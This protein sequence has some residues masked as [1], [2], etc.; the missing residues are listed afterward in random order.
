MKKFLILFIGILSLTLLD[1][2]VKAVNMNQTSA[3]YD[4]YTTGPNGRRIKTQ[5]AYEPAGVVNQGLNLLNP[6]DLY[7]KDDLIYI[8]DTGNKR[9]VK[10][11]LDGKFEV[12]ISN[13]NQPTGIHVD[14]L[15]QI[16]VA[17]KGNKEVY[18]YD[19]N[20]LLLDTFGRPKEPI[21]G[22]NSPYVPTKIVT[23]PRGIMYI[24]GEGSTG[25]LIQL[26]YAGDFLGFYGTNETS[27]TWYQQLAEWFNLD[28]AK[29]IPTS[30]LNLA[31]DLKGSVFTTSVQ[32]SNQIKKFNIASSIVL[33]LSDETQPVSI[34]INDFNNIYTISD[35]G[36]ITEYDSYGN[37][38]FKFGGLDQGN[39][40][41]GLFVNPVD[42][43]LD[44]N[45][46]IYVLDKATSQIQML[47]RA[48]FTVMVHQGLEDFNNGIYSIEQWEEV[49][50]MN[51]MFALANS[52]IARAR[53]R[54]LEYQEALDY[55]EIAADRVGY[56]DSFWQ[57]RYQWMQNYLGNVLILLISFF[58]L[59][60]VLKW[61]DKK[62]HIYDPLRKWQKQLLEIKVIR[63]LSLIFRM[64]R[65]PVDTF[66]EIKRNH[67]SSYLA[68]TI[69]FVI[70]IGLNVITAYQTAFIFNY[71]NL[72]SYSLIREVAVLGSIIILFVFSNY[73]VSTL[74]SGEGFFK[75]IYQT[76]AY[77][78][79]PYIILTIP[80]VLMSHVLTFNEVFIF[81]AM[82]QIK[83]YWSLGL[84]ILM[85]KEVHNYNIKA[86]IKNIFLTLFVMVMIVVIVFL[87]Y[88][89]ANQLYEYVFG[90][91]REVIVRAS[92]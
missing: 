9:I 62:Y 83:F 46:N 47:Q 35:Q 72:E 88:L 84:I 60:K 22:Q 69:L 87:I 11:D 13:L 57:I 45:N 68:S 28:L 37:M 51:S 4:T 71:T 39:R 53:F 74:S 34:A 41:L 76:T 7:I 58:I 31:I 91:I 81:Q 70:F 52:A 78:L 63:E 77:S 16:Y 10:L 50:R 12:V 26:N 65:H 14:E 29:T 75:D 19:Q 27:K 49:L 48:E 3:P 80:V 20:G 2:R 85:M 5:T 32:G 44:S 73:L 21:F 25:G 54:N 67:K 15:N 36:I 79:A 64:F 56:S 17:D 92:H 42:I 8:A 1:V 86:L 66:Y 61:M 82:N 33:S 55:Y 23:G 18:K 38:I 24:A 59:L 89:L 43:A 6:E 30:P 90:I 40:V